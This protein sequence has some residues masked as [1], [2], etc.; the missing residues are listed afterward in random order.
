MNDKINDSRLYR[1]PKLPNDET[2]KIVQAVEKHIN[3]GGDAVS[4]WTP[5]VAPTLYGNTIAKQASL[6]WASSL[7]NIGSHRGRINMLQYGEKGSGKSI[8]LEFWTREL[9]C[10]TVSNRST[11]ASLTVSLNGRNPQPGALAR[12][13]AKGYLTVDELHEFG[14]DQRQAMLQAMESGWYHVS[15]AGYNA[16]LPSKTRILSACNVIK[17]FTPEFLDRWDFKIKY[18][19]YPKDELK[20]IMGTIIDRGTEEVSQHNSG[21]GR[22]IYSLRSFIPEMDSDMKKRTKELIDWVIDETPDNELGVRDN[23]TYYRAIYAVARLNMRNVTE[24]DV[25]IGVNI[26]LDVKKTQENKYDF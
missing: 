13:S 21:L 24:Q 23:L 11:K 2:P 6:L 12:A 9:E 14:H 26:C 17:K 15:G 25:A 19:K 3:S 22:Y 1:S 10:E 7:D 5:H 8:L 20:R 18:H 16:K 4:Y